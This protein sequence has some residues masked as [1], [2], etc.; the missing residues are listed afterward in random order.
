MA[1]CQNNLFNISAIILTNADPFYISYD[2]DK[3]QIKIRKWTLKGH[4]I[5]H[6]HRWAMRCPLYAFWRF[7]YSLWLE[8]KAKGHP[9]VTWPD[10]SAYNSGFY[11][12]VIW[13]G[14]L[15]RELLSPHISRS[16]QLMSLQIPQTGRC[17]IC[18]K[19]EMEI[20]LLIDSLKSEHKISLKICRKNIIQSLR[21]PLICLQK[22]SCNPQEV[23]SKIHT[24]I[25][26]HFH[27]QAMGY[28]LK[29]TIDQS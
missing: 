24:N 11:S 25:F 12:P 10:H 18:Q 17:P 21:Y 4:S 23:F 27:G 29:G 16:S 14:R 19:P 20:M 28:L 3:C 26:S 8:M 7:N 15:V 5:P 9:V 1:C 13:V 22:N 2:N 6:P